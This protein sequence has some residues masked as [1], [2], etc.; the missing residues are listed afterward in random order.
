MQAEAREK[1]RMENFEV[2]LLTEEQ[3]LF[4]VSN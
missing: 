4:I 1:P 2:P 3:C